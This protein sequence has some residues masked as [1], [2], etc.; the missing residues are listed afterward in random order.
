MK[1]IMIE[2]TAQ[3]L[4]ANKRVADGIMDAIS[5]F[6]DGLFRIRIPSVST[7]E[8]APEDDSDE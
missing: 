5:R 3:E 2:C 1:M 7:K 6:A 8:E 4:S